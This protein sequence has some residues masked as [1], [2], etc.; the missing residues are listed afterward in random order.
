M[1]GTERF[2]V[3]IVLVL[4]KYST[5]KNEVQYFHYLLQDITLISY[6]YIPYVHH[7]KISTFGI[8]RVNGTGFS[9]HY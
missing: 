8:D 3:T 2:T 1:S 7:L 9:S 5:M 6:A 4:Y